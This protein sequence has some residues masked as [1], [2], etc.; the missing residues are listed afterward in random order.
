MGFN[1]K[2]HDLNDNKKSIKFEGVIKPNSTEEIKDLGMSI[3]D[4][5]EDVKFGSMYL[6]FKVKFPRK[7][8]KKQIAFI[9]ENF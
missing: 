7:L 3:K 5:S 6:K 8:N 1:Y 9:N 4:N 2:L